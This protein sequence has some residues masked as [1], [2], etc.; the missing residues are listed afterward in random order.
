MTTSPF[1]SGEDVS[2]Q[3]CRALIGWSQSDQEALQLLL[4][5]NPVPTD[6]IVALQQTIAEC[7]AAVASRPAITLTNPVVDAGDDPILR[8]IKERPEVQAAFAGQVWFPGMVNLR[9]VLAFQKIINTEGLES[10]IA[11]A[12][13]SKEG[14]FKLCLPENPPLPPT[15]AMVDLDGKGITVSAL[16]PNLRIL[17]NQVSEAQINTV[18]NTPAMKA[19]A[20]TFFINMGNNYL[21]VVRYNDRYF[22]RDGYHRAVGLLRENIDVVPCIVIEARDFAQDVVSGQQNMFLPYEVLYGPY[23]PRLT[24]FWDDAVSRT[25]MRLTTRKVIRIRGDEFLVQG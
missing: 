5:R 11:S 20:L 4:G 9:E 7:R 10:R 23:P 15:G 12:R 25:V 17:G 18:P 22:I 2:M 16:N 24:D 14:L 13:T 6:D 1:V 21:Q 3:S 19:M 8:E